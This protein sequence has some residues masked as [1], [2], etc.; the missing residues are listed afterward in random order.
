MGQSQS[1]TAATFVVIAV[2]WIPCAVSAQ[3]NDAAGISV[4]II[5][6]AGVDHGTL[7]KAQRL[8]TGVYAR[9]GIT[10]SWSDTPDVMDKGSFILHIVS[11][12][13]G[14]ETSNDRVLGVAPRALNRRG[15][16]A[17]VFYERI[18]NYAAVLGCGVTELLAG[19]MAHELGHLLLDPTSSHGTGVM[20]E[21]WGT[22]QIAAL[23]IGRVSFTKREAAIMRLHLRAET[24][25]AIDLT[26][27][28]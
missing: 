2:I 18:G 24:T 23:R 5:D 8:V 19:V 10:L 20:Q 27:A 3:T 1:F 11:K 25:E 12:S 6:F 26:A 7:K 16:H 9:A 17:W 4:R 21:S 28:R 13:L 14:G 22:P 15:R